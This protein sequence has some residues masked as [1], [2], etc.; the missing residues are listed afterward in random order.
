MNRPKLQDD[1]E[2]WLV[3]E[4]YRF[5]LAKTED[6]S[7][8]IVLRGQGTYGMPVEIFEPVK[9]QGVI[10]LGYKIYLQ[11]RHTAR[12]LRLNEEEQ[13]KFKASI[14]D[15][16]D[17]IGAIQRVFREDGKVVVGVYVVLDKV[18]TFT[19]QIIMDA[20]AQ[21]IEL[22]EKTNRFIIKTF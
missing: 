10:V 15:F 9:Q 19:Q 7:F 5:G 2:R 13:Q 20:I 1:V 14:K 16:C 12:F 22:G 6:D 18:D 17:S 3:H 8:R 11:N 4:N 21:V